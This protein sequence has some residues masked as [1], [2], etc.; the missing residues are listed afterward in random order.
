MLELTSD[1]AAFIRSITGRH[2]IGGGRWRRV[3]DSI[4]RAFREFQ[5]GMPEFDECQRID[6][7]SVDK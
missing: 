3:N 4:W 2:I 5:E 1:E 7:G 6:V